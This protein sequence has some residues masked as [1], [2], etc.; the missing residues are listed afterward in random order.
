MKDLQRKI[1]E[2]NPYKEEFYNDLKFKIDVAEE[3]LEKF[4]FGIIDK[5]TIMIIIKIKI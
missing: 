3:L 5:M 4:D 2:D 1:K